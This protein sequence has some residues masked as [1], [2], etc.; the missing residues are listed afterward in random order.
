MLQKISVI[1][2][3]AIAT[4]SF[5]WPAEAVS[6]ASEAHIFS[7]RDETL[8]YDEPKETPVELTGNL[9]VY[10]K[11]D[12]FTE[13]QQLLEESLQRQESAMKMADAARECGYPEDHPII[14]LAEQEWTNAYELSLIYQTEIDAT[15]LAKAWDEYP[16]ATEVWLY[17]TNTMGY[18]D[19]VAAGI[20]GNM[21]AECGGLT[22]NLDWTATNRYSNCYGLCQW[23]P[24]Y[25][26]EVQGANL[27]KQL[28]Y[29][30]YSFPAILD[31]Y[32]FEY[33]KGFTYKDFLNLTSASEAAE[34][35]CII[36]ER[37]GV[38]DPYRGELADQAYS[39]F[40]K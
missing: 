25:H 26:Q 1:A 19:Y 35:F 16:V 40:V 28:E 13:L 31:Q 14:I 10:T 29:M 8:I 6:T 11:S 17:L 15:K 4:I 12:D 37:P 33:Q 39:Y 23:H 18:S 32:A 21:M 5:S 34:A 38:Y 36:Y 24:K 2:M 20:I 3:A 22:L 27:Q 9:L 7:E 30:S